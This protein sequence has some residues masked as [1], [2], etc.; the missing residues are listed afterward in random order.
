MPIPC[1]RFARPLFS[2]VLLACT[3]VPSARADVVRDAAW[4]DCDKLRDRLTVRHGTVSATEPGATVFWSLVG[5]SRRPDGDPDRVNEL[6]SVRH[7]CRLSGGL[8]EVVLQPVP[9]NANLQGPC[10]A[11][12]RG[13]VTILRNGQPILKER[14]LET[15]DCAGP[16]QR[17]EAITVFGNNEQVIVDLEN[18]PD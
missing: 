1:A 4:V 16:G 8:L 2:L 3:A 17:I 14:E 7:S 9:M 10:G 15:G 12:V 18:T 6:R 13:S 5:Y 11:V